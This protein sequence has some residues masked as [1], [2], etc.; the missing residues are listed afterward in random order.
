LQIMPITPA[1]FEDA[2]SI[3]TVQIRSWQAAYSAILD[4][5]WLL[6]LSVEARAKRWQEILPAGD[7]KTH[8]H[9]HEGR[10]T[11]FVSFGKCRDEGAPGTQGE[12]W[13]L[14]VAPETW[15]QG[16]GRALLEHAVHELRVHA[17]TSVSLWVLKENHRGVRFYEA[18]G[19]ERVPGSGKLFALGGRQVDE[20]AYLLR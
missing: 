14:Y 8:V 10:V 3:A 7:S 6:S 19:F 13:A 12:I 16:V 4:P 5:D 20:I 11:G 18:C 17:F 1:A 15:G 9:R 2:H